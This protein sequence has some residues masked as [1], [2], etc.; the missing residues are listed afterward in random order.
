MVDGHVSRI[1][2]VPLRLRFSFWARLVFEN[3]TSHQPTASM[4]TKPSWAI[5]PW[6]E[7]EVARTPIIAAAPR[8]AASVMT[9]YR[10]IAVL[11]SSVL[12]EIFEDR[13]Y[14]QSPPQELPDPV[15]EH[16][17]GGAEGER[18]VLRLLEEGAQRAV[19]DD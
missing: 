18:D 5:S 10:L 4:R 14:G 17:Q 9:T 3:L 16:T 13:P 19:L 12:L 2:A 8:R 1:F 6:A 7:T 15:P 11:P